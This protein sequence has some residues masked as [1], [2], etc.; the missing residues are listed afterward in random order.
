MWKVVELRVGCGSDPTALLRALGIRDGPELLNQ[1]YGGLIVG[2]MELFQYQLARFF[3]GLAGSKGRIWL[4]VQNQN[5]IMGFDMGPGPLS[6]A[7]SYTKYDHF[8]PPLAKK[9][10]GTLFLLM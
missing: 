6:W 5:R 10:V 4:T 7:T 1:R 2:E 9:R 3:L 8:E